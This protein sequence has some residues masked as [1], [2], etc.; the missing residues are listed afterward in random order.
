MHRKSKN[1]MLMAKKGLDTGRLTRSSARRYRTNIGEMLNGY[2]IPLLR[3]AHGGGGGGDPLR[4]R[5]VFFQAPILINLTSRVVL[6]ALPTHSAAPSVILCG[7]LDKFSPNL[8]SE[9]RRKPQISVHLAAL[10]V[11]I[12]FSREQE[13]GP[14]AEHGEIRGLGGGGGLRATQKALACSRCWPAR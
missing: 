10:P 4:S 3:F 5:P 6:G 7:I 9:S 8:S 12:I 2:F 13:N 14:P 11:V 1:K